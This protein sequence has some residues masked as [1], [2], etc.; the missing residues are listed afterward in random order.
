MYKSLVHWSATKN[1][2]AFDFDNYEVTGPITLYAVFKATEYKVYFDFN[3]GEGDDQI[4]FDEIFKIVQIDGNILAGYIDWDVD[5]L[6]RGFNWNECDDGEGSVYEITYSLDNMTSNKRI[7]SVKPFA[8][9]YTFVGWYEG[10]S[11]SAT[12][13]IR[14]PNSKTT[15]ITLTAKWKRTDYTI[16]FDYQ[17]NT[18]IKSDEFTNLTDWTN[19]LP[20]EVPEKTGS[21]F[22]G[23]SV[24]SEYCD[25]VYDF[26]RN[27]YYDEDTDEDLALFCI[28]DFVEAELTDAGDGYT[29]TLYAIWEPKPVSIR[30]ADNASGTI[31][32]IK[33]NATLGD[34][35]TVYVGDVLTVKVAENP[36]YKFNN[37]V[38]ET[39]ENPEYKLRD[40]V[41]T[42]TVTTSLVNSEEKNG[43]TVYYISIDAAYTER[44]F[45]IKYELDGGHSDDSTFAKSFSPSEL[46]TTSSKR[47]ILPSKLTKN[48]YDF[49]GWIYAGTENDPA[50]AYAHD[51]Q[52]SYYDKTLYLKKPAQIEL[53]NITLVATWKAQPATVYL[54]NATYKGNVY[55]KDTVNNNY[56][57]E[58]YE[59]VSIVTGSKIT[60]ESPERDS[61]KF[62]GWATTRNGTVVY[63]ATQYDDDDKAAAIPYTVNADHDTAGNKLNRNNLYAVWH[64]KDVDYIIMSAANNNCTYGTGGIKLTAVPSHDYSNSGS[65]ITLTYR[66]YRVYAGMYDS[67]FTV[68]DYVDKNGYK[69][70]VDE[71]GDITAYEKDGKYYNADKSEEITQAIAEAYGTKLTIKD[72]NKASVGVGCVEMFTKPSVAP[73]VVPEV[74]VNNVVN[75]GTYICV[76]DVVASDGGSESRA[77][78]YGEIEIS[79]SKATYGNLKLESQENEYDTTEQW[80]SVVLDFVKADANST[81]PHKA[82]DGMLKLPDGS[83]LI[84]TYTYYKGA[85]ELVNGE[86][87]EQ[88]TDLSQIKNVGEYHVVVS[89]DWAVDG[90]K[91]NYEELEELEAD[92][93]IR[94]MTINSVTPK[95]VKDGEVIEGDFAGEYDG[96]SYGVDFV[97]N[98]KVKVN[99]VSTKIT[100]IDD[101]AIDVKVFRMTE[102]GDVA[103]PAA[104]LPTTESGAYAVVMQENLKGEEA[105]NYILG[106]AVVRR[107]E[108]T[109]GQ[110]KFEVADH[111]HFDDAEYVYDGKTKTVSI[112][113]DE[114]YELPESIEVKYSR[115]YYAEDTDGTTKNKTDNGGVDAGIYVITVTFEF[116][117][118][119]EGRAAA[120]NYEKLADMTATLTIKKADFLDFHNV[121]GKDML[122]DGGFTSASYGFILNTQYHPYL[123]V[124]KIDAEFPDFNSTELAVTYTYYRVSGETR[125]CLTYD[126]N[127][128]PNMTHEALVEAGKTAKFISNAGKYEIVAHIE[129]KSWNL[130]NNYEE[131]DEARTTITYEIESKGVEKVEVIWADGFDKK[132]KLGEAFDYEWI[133]Q[134]NVTYEDGAGTLE[135]T[136]PADIDLAVIEYGKKGGVEQSNYWHVGAFNTLTISYY[137]KASEAYTFTVYEDVNPSTTTIKYRVGSEDAYASIPEGGL[138]LLSE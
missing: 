26:S 70:Y 31:S 114:G 52:D 89:F 88:I 41:T 53:D 93:Y 43:E 92:L 115:E 22:V 134:I 6:F 15:D 34:N 68:K 56:Y 96:S 94:P 117:D 75:C 108:Y 24:N 46:L 51:A 136:A 59:G 118:T 98:D 76:V 7:T 64:V 97:I 4:P 71:N 80:G 62:L 35:A 57:I 12:E 102:N 113:F 14:V 18:R 16:R 81:L 55:N 107:K 101:V 112:S 124:A 1:G 38:F 103:I 65:D 125:T 72:F 47:A 119:E 85:G 58:E 66:W 20:E 90:D 116:K 2:E 73:G 49:D 126:S 109:I 122:R 106:G 39:P 120:N 42:F 3:A 86:E 61:F 83:K 84:V 25:D 8:V 60:I 79:M 135:V 78:G 44:R 138:P 104:Q 63:P 23:W 95:F 9:G 132:V 121:D 50:P 87:R 127:D 69:W 17:N 77:E 99:E 30:K 74:T 137:G 128:N 100:D 133:K 82:S 48:G 111:I 32:L 129:Y 110:A 37:L 45:T 5:T 123:D 67:C 33:D 29:V 28:A 13:V 130:S 40:F 54:Y 21:S 105:D 36:G 27:W 10:T 131:L 19:I 11:A 91:G